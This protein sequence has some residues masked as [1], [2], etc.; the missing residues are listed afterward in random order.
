MTCFRCSSPCQPTLVI[1]RSPVH[2]NLTRQWSINL[3]CHRSRDGVC[4]FLWSANSQ[5]NWVS[6]TVDG[7]EKATL[8]LSI[9][10]SPF[11]EF[12]DLRSGSKSPGSEKA[13]DRTPESV[14]NLGEVV[15]LSTVQIKLPI[16]WQE[17]TTGMITQVWWILMWPAGRSWS[18]QVVVPTTNHTQ[19]PGTFSAF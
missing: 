1:T 17:E 10:R 15:E 12:Y 18:T 4:Q 2:W 6:T 7:P 11:L 3:R 8:R 9:L 14:V 19:G 5:L 16:Q 13:R